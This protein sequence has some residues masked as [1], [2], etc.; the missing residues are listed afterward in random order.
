LSLLSSLAKQKRQYSKSLGARP[1]LAS[2][3]ES[4]KENKQ[5][6]Q[7]K[8]LFFSVYASR[9]EMFDRHKKYI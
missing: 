1:C 5:K 6:Q 3:L 9:T 8:L 4:Y 7:P 2:E